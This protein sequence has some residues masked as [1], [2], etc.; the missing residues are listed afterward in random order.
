[1]AGVSGTEVREGGTALGYAV[2]DL[3]LVFSL[4]TGGVNTQCLSRR[5][6]RAATRFSGWSSSEEYGGARD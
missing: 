3:E 2:E 5:I 6:K 4:E 1:M